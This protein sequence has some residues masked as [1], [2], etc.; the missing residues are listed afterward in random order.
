MP[1]LPNPLVFIL[2]SFHFTL[3]D[4]SPPLPLFC[5]SPMFDKL[6]FIKYMKNIGR[7]YRNQATVLVSICRYFEQTKAQ[8]PGSD[9]ELRR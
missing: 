8:T 3:S 6:A 4:H 9:A 1:P 2:C 5:Q 7:A